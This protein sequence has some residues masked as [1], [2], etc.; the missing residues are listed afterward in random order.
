MASTTFSAVRVVFTTQ[1]SQTSSECCW[2][3]GGGDTAAGEAG[4]SGGAGPPPPQHPKTQHSPTCVAAGPVLVVAQVAQVP[5][6]VVDGSAAVVAEGA[7]AQGVTV[8]TGLG[9]LGD[10]LGEGNGVGVTPGLQPDGGLQR[11]KPGGLGWRS[12]NPMGGGEPQWGE[13]GTPT[14]R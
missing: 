2:Q 7:P 4:A 3:Q 9:G 13:D 12:P 8:G 10:V 11:G 5:L 6:H 1:L 14:G